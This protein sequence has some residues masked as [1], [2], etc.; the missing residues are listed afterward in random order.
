MQ[1]LIGVLLIA[2]SATAFGTMPVFAS[3]AYAANADPMTILF[4]RFAIASL[5]LL[6]FMMIQRIPFPKGLNLLGL[7]ALG[8]VGFVLQSLCYFTALTLAPSGLVALL[9]YLYPAIVTMLSSLLLKE[10]LT[11]VKIGALG[12]ALAGLVFTIGP[13]S[14]GKIL[15]IVLGV[16]SALI[17]SIYLLAGNRI[18]QQ[19]ESIPACTVIVTSAAVVFGGLVGINGAK[20]PTTGIGWVSIGAIALISSVLAIITLLAGIKR[21]GSTNAATLSTLEPVVT[22]ILGALI[23]NE[24]ITPI[25]IMGGVMILSAVTILAKT[26]LSI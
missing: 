10:P 1:R 5:C 25:Q 9:L 4:L 22:V 18:I 16:T 13:E 19:E 12:L 14:G 23:L 11:K 24:T 3:F 6:I 8:G 21:I 26:E 15:G 20:L 17:Y 2:I 7:M